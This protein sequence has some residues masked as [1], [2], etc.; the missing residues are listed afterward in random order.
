[1]PSSVLDAF[2]NLRRPTYRI[3]SPVTSRTHFLAIPVD[4]VP[5]IAFVVLRVMLF[6]GSVTALDGVCR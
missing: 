2:A 3:V 1:M 4:R 6:H 5:L